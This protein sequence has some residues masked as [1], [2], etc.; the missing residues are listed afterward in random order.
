MLILYAV[1]VGSDG[2]NEEWIQQ[3]LRESGNYLKLAYFFIGY[4][5]ESTLKPMNYEL[6]KV[7]MNY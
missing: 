7:I 1:S 6:L 3:A 2:H 5:D 4:L